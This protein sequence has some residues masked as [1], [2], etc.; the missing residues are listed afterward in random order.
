MRVYKISLIRT[1]PISQKHLQRRHTQ[2]LPRSRSHWSTP[3]SRSK[4]H[5]KE[6]QEKTTTEKQ[7]ACWQIYIVDQH[8][9]DLC[10]SP[11]TQT[12]LD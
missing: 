12:T 9:S 11:D 3:N 6:K 10:P 1:L 7:H 5:S 4:S 8:W 2:N